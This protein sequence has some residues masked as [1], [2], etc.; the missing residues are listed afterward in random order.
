M[1]ASVPPAEG[2]ARWTVAQ[3]MGIKPGIRAHLVAAPSPAVLALQLPTLVISPEL[4]GQFDYLHLFTT[5]QICVEDSFPI[6]KGH[7]TAAGM[8]WVSWPKA[9][10]LGTDL[11][12]PTVIR[13][14][15]SHGMVESTCLSVDDTWSALKF[16]HPKPGKTYN[17]SHGTLPARCSSSASLNTSR[18]RP[19]AGSLSGDERALRGGVGGDPKSRR[20]RFGLWNDCTQA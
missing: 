10:K 1:S 7:L 9:K 13:I 12:L 18:R 2:A 5:S 3:K 8:L 17:N 6:L 20:R 14:G 15:Y 4:D 11:S 16:T 19:V